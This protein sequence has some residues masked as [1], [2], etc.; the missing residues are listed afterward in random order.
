MKLKHRYNTNDGREIIGR[1][2]TRFARCSPRKVRLVVDTIRNKTVAE[3][4]EILQFTQRPSAVPYVTKALKAA[5][6][7][8]REFNSTPEELVIGE[9]IVNEAPTMKRIRPASMGRATRVRKRQSHIFLGL[10]EF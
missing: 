10:T 8:A 3:A 6:A 4:L 2:L 1:S 7:S 9:A 5:V